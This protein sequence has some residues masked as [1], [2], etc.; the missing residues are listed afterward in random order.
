MLPRLA[1]L[2]LLVSFGTQARWA[3]CRVH[4]LPEG[5]GHTGIANEC[6]CLLREPGSLYFRQ[7]KQAEAQGLHSNDT[8][9]FYEGAAKQG[10]EAST[11]PACKLF[12]ISAARLRGVA[13]V[14]SKTLLLTSFCLRQGDRQ[15]CRFIPQTMPEQVRFLLLMASQWHVP[16]GGAVVCRQCTRLW[17][18]QALL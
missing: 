13:K 8:S 17:L 12:T 7:A 3:K 16:A 9:V 1:Q 2:L 6:D 5:D 4:V 11:E 10:N 18:G 14:H 15:Y